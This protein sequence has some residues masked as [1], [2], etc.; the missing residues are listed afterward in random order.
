[1]SQMRTTIRSRKLN[2]GPGKVGGR[3]SAILSYHL[4]SST[5][6]FKGCWNWKWSQ[7]LN[8]GTEVENTG[9]LTT[10]PNDDSRQKSY[11]GAN[12]LLLSEESLDSFFTVNTSSK[13][14]KTFSNT[15]ANQRCLG[16]N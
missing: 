1:M 10:A 7:S 12:L 13:T 3:S 8:L 16:I 4:P 14:L 5:G 2:P 15:L 6:A 9:I 11:G